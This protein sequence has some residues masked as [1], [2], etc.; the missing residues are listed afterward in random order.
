MVFESPVHAVVGTLEG[1]VVLRKAADNGA[2]F[3]ACLRVYQ[4]WNE[5]GKILVSDRC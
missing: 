2:S 4:S 3:E 5:V 1:G